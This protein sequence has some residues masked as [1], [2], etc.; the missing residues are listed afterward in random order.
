MNHQE[1]GAVISILV[2]AYPTQARDEA[3]L[4]MLAGAMMAS[5]VT[6][7]GA[8][9]RAEEWIRSE[10]FWPAISDMAQRPEQSTRVMAL[11]APANP[12]P[13]ERGLEILREAIR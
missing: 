5:G 3:F 13:T 10:R 2:K 6:L 12:I 4:T 1:A 8:R 11:I 9:S 7:D